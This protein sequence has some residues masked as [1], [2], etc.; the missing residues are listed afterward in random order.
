[1]PS[2][3]AL[4]RPLVDGNLDYWPAYSLS[5]VA[6]IPVSVVL[7]RHVAG[8]WEVEAPDDCGE[9][10]Q[11]ARRALMRGRLRE[12]II[13]GPSVF[14][15]SVDMDH[16]RARESGQF[17]GGGIGYNRHAQLSRRRGVALHHAGAVREGEAA[18]SAVK[19]A[20]HALHRDVGH[21]AG[22]R[23]RA[24]DHFSM[25]DAFEVT[26]PGLLG[27]EP[28][29]VVPLL[30]VGGFGGSHLDVEQTCGMDHVLLVLGCDTHRETHHRRYHRES[31]SHIASEMQLTEFLIR[32]RSYPLRR[33]APRRRPTLHSPTRTTMTSR[34]I[35]I[36][37]SPRTSILPGID[38]QTVLSSGLL[39]MFSS[40]V[41]SV[42]P[43]ARAVP[44]MIRSAGSC[45]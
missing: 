4:S 6:I 44:P 14:T 38:H 13:E 29:N 8:C 41:I 17:S 43:S 40:C 24:G 23:G 26:V 45:E 36:E 28:G 3:F 27:C 42:R 16:E 15:L 31:H 39:R 18:R 21:G 34:M 11:A 30:E 9:D 12:R 19:L 2:V 35:P 1:M 33:L 22:A 10:F 32:T 7:P 25:A 5:L 20:G 37:S